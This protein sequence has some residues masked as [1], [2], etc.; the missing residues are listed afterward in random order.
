[1]AKAGF[2][3]YHVTQGDGGTTSEDGVTIVTFRGGRGFA[4]RLGQLRRLYRTAASLDAGCYHC[5]ELESWFVGVLMKLRKRS[6]LVFDVHEL[7]SARTAELFPRLLRPAVATAVRLGFRMLLPFTDQ[8]IFA[9]PSVGRD[10]PKSLEP[11][12][13]QNFTEV[14]P[15][16][17]ERD[18]DPSAPEP[19][20]DD[21]NPVVAVHVGAIN[22]ARGWPQLLDAVAMTNECLQLRVIG[23]F[24]DNTDEEF[25]ARCDELGIS[26]RVR[27][28]GWIPYEEVQTEL[29]ACDIGLITFQ[30]TALNFIYAMPHK[31]FDY[32]LAGIPVIVP[33]YAVDVAAIVRDADCGFLVDATDPAA[34]AAAL[35][36]LG[37]DA[38]QRRH[39]GQNGRRAVLERYNWRTEA[40]KL[41]AAYDALSKTYKA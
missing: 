35:D 25:A 13:V 14:A 30:P 41:V 12:I 8:V 7:Y 36:E 40:D 23:M 21:G 10:F 28:D 33:E 11:L 34:L 32:M 24:G 22:R 29:H 26:P 31:L 1:M 39:L 5:N 18:H 16:E 17:V 9:K 38:V 3:V 20:D 15:E 4:S 37:K 6:L 27:F 19:A 2:D